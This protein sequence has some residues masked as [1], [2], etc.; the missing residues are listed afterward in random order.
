VALA[1]PLIHLYWLMR[2]QPE[3]MFKATRFPPGICGAQAEREHG[4]P[5][6]EEDGLAPRAGDEPRRVC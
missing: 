2:G 6:P 1:G 3:E 5:G 4:D